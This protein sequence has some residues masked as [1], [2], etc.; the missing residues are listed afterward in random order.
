MILLTHGAA[1]DWAIGVRTAD[2]VLDVAAAA[3]DAGWT[4]EPTAASVLAA[5]LDGLAD[6]AGL[7]DRSR[8]RPDLHLD[9]ATLRLGPAVSSPPKILGIGLNYRRHAEESGQPIPAFPVVFSKFSNALAAHGQPIA[10]PAGASEYDY[11]VELAV[12]IG[13]RA[14]DV[15][16]AAALDVVL[17]YATA[18]DFSARDLQRRTSQW[19]LGKTF[20][21]ALPIGPYLVTCDEV[22]DPQAL[23]LRTWVNGE[24]RQDS[25]TSDMVFGVRHLV[26]YLSQY[27]T[28]ERGDVILT[29]TPSG[30]IAGMAEPIWLRAGDEVSVEVAGLGRLD[31]WLVAP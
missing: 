3:R 20:D 14:R 8:G 11:E 19:L 18:N 17:G 26:S 10:L 6:L 12:V 31:N 21:G 25:S 30:V 29:G 16:E 15:T 27:M 9:E 7:V 28:L 23:G 2:G 13:R 1:P 4:R 22:P 24:L 5:G